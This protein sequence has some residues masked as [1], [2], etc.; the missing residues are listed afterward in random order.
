M[1]SSS[2]A[3][4]SAGAS[5]SDSGA[6][7]RAAARRRARSFAVAAQQAAAAGALHSTSLLLPSKDGTVVAAKV[8][9]SLLSSPAGAADEGAAEEGVEPEMADGPPPEGGE[10]GPR[11]ARP[12]NSVA[13]WFGWSRVVALLLVVLAAADALRLLHLTE[14]IVRDS[15][16]APPGASKDIPP[17]VR[18]MLDAWAGVEPTPASRMRS[19]T[20]W[21]SAWGLLPGHDDVCVPGAQ[22]HRVECAELMARREARAAQKK[23]MYLPGP[24]AED[25]RPVDVLE[26]SR[27]DF[28]FGALCLTWFVTSTVTLALFLLAPIRN[29]MSTIRQLALGFCAQR[30]KTIASITPFAVAG[31]TDEKGSAC[32]TPTQQARART[33]TLIR[34]HLGMLALGASSHFIEMMA[35]DRGWLDMRSR[36]SA[37][38][39]HAAWSLEPLLSRDDG[40][41]ARA[42]IEAVVFVLHACRVG[43]WLMAAPKFAGACRALSAQLRAL[44]LALRSGA[45]GLPQA[46]VWLHSVVRVC[47]WMARA[48]NK[49]AFV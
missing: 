47:V 49:F 16:T 30:D 36:V 35:Y 4:G 21:L 23:L 44:A 18:W 2:G 45:V 32:G 20:D 15:A 7:D 3:T 31:Y 8:R 12:N 5:G 13:P 34:R 11:S 1:D 29:D 19:A 40:P 24:P 14:G 42:L 38:T 43:A 9:R 28:A 17:S 46:H 48:A 26:L 27:E 33:S 37:Y 25:D 41:V 39:Y 22:Y 10:H 6:T